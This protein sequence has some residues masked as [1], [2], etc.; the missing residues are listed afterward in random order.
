MNTLDAIY[1]R[2][3]IRSFT[4]ESISAEELDTILKA[5]NASPVGRAQYDTVNLTVI[6]N[7][8][9]LKKIEAAAATMM[10]NPELR[11]L[12]NAPTMILV[13]A[14]AP[15]VPAAQ[16]I[17]Y[18]NAAIIAHNMALAATELGVGVCHI[19][20]A[21]GALATAPELVKELNLPEGF[22]PCCAVIVGKTDIAYAVREIP[23]R[24]S[25]NT[26]E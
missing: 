20:G 19:W 3:S 8:E 6:T 11:P 10:G 13:S 16:N 17:T 12:Y 26:V 22:I 9:L 1:S 23:N 4:G 21:I 2:Q 18:S 5:A 7:A 15:A 14:K 24:I 25:L